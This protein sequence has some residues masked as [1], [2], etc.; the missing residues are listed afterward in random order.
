MLAALKADLHVHTC[1]SPCADDEMKPLAIVKQAR[2]KGVDLIGICDHNSAGNV[3]AARR[4]GSREGVAVVGGIEVSSREEVHVLGLFDTQED[5]QEM[6]RLIDRNLSGENNPELFGEQH[7]CNEFDKIIGRDA[8]LL[9]AATR[10]TV[11]EVVENIHTLGGLAIASHVDRESFSILGQ[12]GF[13][14]ERLAIDALEVSLLCT[15]ALARQR[16]PQTRGYPLVCFS[17]AHRLDDI[18]ETTTA[19]T[20]AGP[21]VDELRKALWCENGRTTAG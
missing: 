15:M 21:C 11:E 12:L 4:A 19:F 20:V 8:R 6:Q 3:D 18:G 16:F 1:L 2:R 9:I 13:V 10:L 17:D 14:P 7:I 5:L